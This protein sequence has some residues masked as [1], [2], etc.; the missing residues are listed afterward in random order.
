M[1]DIIKEGIKSSEKLA[2][3]PFKAVRE[4][5]GES[6]KSIAEFTGL[7]EDIVSIPFKL[8]N[9][10]IEGITVEEQENGEDNSQETS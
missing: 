7:A 5:T 2:T 4:I 1:L 9:Q 3:L 6:N 10:A 8:A